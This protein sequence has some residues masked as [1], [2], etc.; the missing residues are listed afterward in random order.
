MGDGTI[1]APA[2]KVVISCVLFFESVFRYIVTKCFPQKESLVVVLVMVFFRDKLQH[3]VTVHGSQ[4]SG[5]SKKQL[6]AHGAKKKK[7]IARSS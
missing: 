5:N 7:L 6:I 2:D 1:L 4:L 3:L